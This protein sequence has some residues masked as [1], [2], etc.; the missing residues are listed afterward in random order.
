LSVALNNAFINQ[1]SF[2]GKQLRKPVGFLLSL[3]V[4]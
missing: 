2:N 1:G 3:P 4:R